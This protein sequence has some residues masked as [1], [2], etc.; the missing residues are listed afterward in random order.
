MKKNIIVATIILGAATLAWAAPFQFN[1]I[2]KEG[3]HSQ[4]SMVFR[5]LFNQSV[6]PSSVQ[7]RVLDSASKDILCT[8]PTPLPTQLAH[9]MTFTLKPECNKIRNTA[10][11]S[12]NHQIEVL[13]TYD[14]GAT[15]GSDY[16]EYQVDN[17]P[18]VAVGCAPTPT[19]AP[20]AQD[21]GNTPLPTNTP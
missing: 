1:Q 13:F 18:Q 11:N 2:I 7:V 3:S 15:D 6:V 12:E 8:L 4:V 20:A 9:S 5:N 17:L 21:C 14:A 16:A 19:G 10:R